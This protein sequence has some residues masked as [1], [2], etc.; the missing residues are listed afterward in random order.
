LNLSLRHV[1][2]ST[3]GLVDQIRELA[4]RKLQLTL[5][6]SLHAPNDEVRSQSMPV[7]RKYPI[8]ELLAA[9]RDY[10]SATGRRISF[11]YALISGVN[12]SPETRGGAGF[13]AARM[14]RARQP[15]PCEPCRGNGLPARRQEE[16]RTLQHSWSGWASTRPSGGA[17]RRYF[18]R[19][20]AIC[21]GRTLRMG[22][23][24]GSVFDAAGIYKGLNAFAKEL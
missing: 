16:D 6:V 9:C 1:S 11:E 22:K 21:A 12:D 8:D 3:C 18:R 23:G 20:R 17:G 10:F 2:L 19:V 5:S 4:K 14:A 7:N 13:K 24:R 15:D